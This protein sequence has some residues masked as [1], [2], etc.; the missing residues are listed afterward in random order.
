MN[1]RATPFVDPLQQAQRAET[2]RA[3]REGVSEI[4]D[5]NRVR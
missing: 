4:L 1:G 2:D 3:V 5:D